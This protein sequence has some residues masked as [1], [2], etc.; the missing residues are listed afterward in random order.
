MSLAEFE[1]TIPASELPQ[2]EALDRAG[3]I[4]THIATNVKF[5]PAF[6]ID[7]VP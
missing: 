5:A 6:M 2:I 7:A 1:P 3:V 4:P